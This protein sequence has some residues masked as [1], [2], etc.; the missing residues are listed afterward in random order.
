MQADLDG[1]GTIDYMEFIGATIHMS[2]A[3]RDKQLHEAFRYFD[4]DDSG[5]V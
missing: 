2:K 4:K 5:W 3:N 1:S